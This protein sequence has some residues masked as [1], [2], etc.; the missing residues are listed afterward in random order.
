MRR[1]NRQLILA[2]TPGDEISYIS[3]ERWSDK[4]VS[5][6]AIPGAGGTAPT[7]ALAR[8]WS[9][10][11]VPTIRIQL[12][13]ESTIASFRAL[14][15]LGSSVVERPPPYQAWGAGAMVPADWEPYLSPDSYGH[16]GA[17]GLAAFADPNHRFRIRLRHQSHRRSGTRPPHHCSSRPQPQ[18]IGFIGVWAN[19][20]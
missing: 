15:S 20:V 5:E 4:E 11:V 12:L 6:A 3:G 14:R 16:A 8:M 13:Q 7:P 17:G 10:T 9:A 2:Q 18:R 19:I 1:L